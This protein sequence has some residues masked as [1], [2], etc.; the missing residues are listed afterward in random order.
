VG[1]EVLVS[2]D[3]DSYKKVADELGLEHQICRHH[4]KENVDD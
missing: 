2:D 1:A 4:V 3:L